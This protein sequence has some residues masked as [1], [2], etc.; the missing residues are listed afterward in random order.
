MTM[1]NND[2]NITFKKAPIVAVLL[3]GTFI[4][5]LNQTLLATAIPKIMADLHITANTAQ[6][7]N[8]VFMLVNGIMIPI[9]AFLIE[10]Y[11][12]RSLY[13]TAMGLFAA[14]T[15]VCAVS[16]T[17]SVLLLGRIIQA[18]GAGITIPLMQTVMFLI[19]PVERR[20]S[21]MGM[22]G[23]VISFAPAIGPTLSGW[24]VE[25]YPWTTLFYLIFPIA[26]IDIVFAYFLLKN[27]TEQTYPKVD[28]R[29]I[30]LSTFGF[31]GL[32][33]GFSQAGISGWSSASVIFSLVTGT[34]FLSAF[35]LRQLRLQQPIL[36][37]RVFR[38]GLFTLTTA[39]GIVVFMSMIGAATILPIY[40]Q[41]MH[42]FSAFQSGLMLLPGAVV[43]GIMSPI[44]GRIFDKIGARTLAITGMSIL[45]ITT[46]AFT[47]LTATTS[48]LY[49]TTMHAL[50][51][52]GM[53][54]V[55]MPVTTAGLNVLPH[56][57]IPHG[58][59]MNNTMR[60]VGGSI[61]TAL[62]VTIMTNQALSEAQVATSR[63][64][65][66]GVN[67]S[68]MVACMLSAF[69]LL[70]S[71]FIKKSPRKK[72]EKGKAAQNRHYKQKERQ[73]V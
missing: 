68:F 43:M 38:Y 57:L 29:S 70:L 71:F 30:V 25:Q 12:T 59:A 9:T 63:A 50:R 73:P 40:M 44:T 1:N 18:A 15:L 37:F 47:Q 66:H 51:M 64:M 14:G 58:T 34:I 41:N 23:L 61:G 10:R 13:L 55:M 62:L 11:T 4:A 20:G 45:T 16:P 69:G 42:H 52:F 31:G 33:Y 5:I 21:A 17:F 48:F 2:Q 24:M 56:H 65:I 26:V 53:A 22:V 46:L 27:V 67:V 36:E 60:Q 54:M 35:I 6:W 8:T 19:F 32:L 39:I 49:L 3:A 7:L 28:V 72:P